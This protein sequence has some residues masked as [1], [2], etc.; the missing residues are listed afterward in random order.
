M[1]M[2]KNETLNDILE[3]VLT[4]QLGK[5][6]DQLENFLLGSQRFQAERE[7]LAGIRNDYRLMADYWL[8][9]FDDP[10]RQQ[11]YDRLLRRLYVL[12]TNVIIR[13]RLHHNMYLQIED[14]KSVV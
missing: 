4:R 3:T 12:V 10:D 13:D 11:V 6:A 8:K 2:W 5:A 7:Q 1:T 14:R 9:G